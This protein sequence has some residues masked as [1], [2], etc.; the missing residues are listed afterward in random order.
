MAKHL[1]FGAAGRHAEDRDEHADTHDGTD[2]LEHRQDRAACR[3]VLGREIGCAA[4]QDRRQGHSG[5]RADREPARQEVSGVVR[6]VP[7]PGREQDGPEAYEQWAFFCRFSA[8]PAKI[9]TVAGP[10]AEA[11]PT[12]IAE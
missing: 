5:A 9:G 4:G 6:L 11:K 10:G 1:Q 3:R 2:L 7:K 8:M 12:L